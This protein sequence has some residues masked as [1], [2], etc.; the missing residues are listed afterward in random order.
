MRLL[1]TNVFQRISLF[2]KQ[3]Q[4]QP[5]IICAVLSLTQIWTYRITRRF[6]SLVSFNA[7]LKEFRTQFGGAKD[8]AFFLFRVTK[9]YAW[10]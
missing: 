7:K 6:Y 1:R 8:R 10:L 3:G 5:L 9:I 4:F 2:C